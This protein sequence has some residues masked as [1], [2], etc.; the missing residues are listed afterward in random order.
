[1][2]GP[3]D[4]RPVAPGHGAVEGVHAGGVDADLS[5]I[6]FGRARP[7]CFCAT[8]CLTSNWFG[9]AMTGVAVISSCCSASTPPPPPSWGTRQRRQL[10]EEGE[11]REKGRVK[12]DGVNAVA[13]VTGRN[14]M[15]LDGNDSSLK[16][17]AINT[18]C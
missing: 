2:D 5:K 9:P 6:M 12:V 4:G 10:D 3:D 1:M 13:K 11:D 7:L 17:D 16:P 8:L 14:I 15:S 18:L